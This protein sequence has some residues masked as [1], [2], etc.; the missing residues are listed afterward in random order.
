MNYV[1]AE[2]RYRD[3][4]EYLSHGGLVFQKAASWLADRGLDVQW[5]LD[6]AWAFH[7][8]LEALRQ[9]YG[10]TPPQAKK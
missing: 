2:L 8:E 9:A 4:P 10:R 5:A 6:E 1:F 3:A 7:L